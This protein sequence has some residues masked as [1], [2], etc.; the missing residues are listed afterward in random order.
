[1]LSPTQ[2][3]VFFSEKWLEEEQDFHWWRLGMKLIRCC[4]RQDIE[5]VHELMKHVAI[6][7]NRGESKYYVNGGIY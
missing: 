3:I 1:M 6:Y 2:K 7:N 5:S 4:R